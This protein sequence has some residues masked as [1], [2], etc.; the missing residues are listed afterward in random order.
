ML[1]LREWRTSVTAVDGRLVCFNGETNSMNQASLR[2]VSEYHVIEIDDRCL[3]YRPRVRTRLS[4][5]SAPFFRAQ[6]QETMLAE[7]QVIMN[8]FTSFEENPGTPVFARPFV[9]ICFRDPLSFTEPARRESQYFFFS[10]Y[11]RKPSPDFYE[12][13][14]RLQS[15][16]IHKGTRK[17]SN[18]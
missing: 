16:E 1:S 5:T 3:R 12:L 2:I 6:F 18:C 13:V 7:G 8:A 10:R 14:E 11:L 15:W 17:T 9:A 4:L